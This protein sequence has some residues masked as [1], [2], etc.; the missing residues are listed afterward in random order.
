MEEKDIF[1][2]IWKKK[3]LKCLPC[4][5]YFALHHERYKVLYRAIIKEKEL[6][7]QLMM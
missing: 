4:M 1:L 6:K 7:N 3:I 5:V 2:F